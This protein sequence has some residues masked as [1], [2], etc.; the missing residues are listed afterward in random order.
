MVDCGLEYIIAH[1]IP[2]RS[3]R[4]ETR[5]TWKIRREDQQVTG[6]GDYIL[7]TIRNTFF[8]VGVREA[9]MHTDHERVLEVLQGEGV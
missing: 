5:R 3:Y 7:G 8:N 4:G 9:R 6:R 1:F 2:T